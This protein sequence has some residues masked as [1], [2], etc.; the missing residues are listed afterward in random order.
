MTFWD[1]MR[2]IMKRAKDEASDVAQVA[3]IKLEIRNLEGK[4]DH[5]LKEIGRVVCAMPDR[6]SRLSEID[7]LCSEVATVERRI[8]A[9]QQ[10]LKNP[11]T[12]P[13]RPADASVNSPTA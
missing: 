1:T 6:S 5:L 9:L 3:S 10:D 2:R 7:P 4:R 12:R 8:S 11:R 13:P